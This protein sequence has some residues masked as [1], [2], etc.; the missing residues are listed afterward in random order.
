[1]NKTSLILRIILTFFFAVIFSG[2]MFAQSLEERVKKNPRQALSDIKSL[3]ADNP[4][5]E[6]TL[7]LQAKAYENLGEQDTAIRLYQVFI[8]RYPESPEAYLNLA[9]IYAKKGNTNKARQLLEQGLLSKSEYA[10]LYQSLKKLNSHL[11]QSAY[12]R[13]LSKDKKLSVPALATASTLSLPEIRI[14]EVEVIK[15]I[16]VEV[17]KRVEVIKE[18]PVE[19]IKEVEIVKEVEVIREVVKEIPVAASSLAKNTS[20]SK[21]AAT[22]DASVIKQ[23]VKNKDL[24]PLVEQWA[25]AW[26]DQN[27]GRF[28]SFY[29]P[30]YASRGK[31]RRQWLQDRKL[32]LTNKRFINVKVSEFVQKVKDNKT[33]DITFKQNYQSDVVQGVSTK[34]LTFKNYDGIWKIVAE[35]IIR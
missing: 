7:F 9:N 17:V 28:V 35:R 29:S 16:P 23:T 27:V 24:V 6:S 25:V 32:K 15:E 3:L 19:V 12:Q 20:T 30:S 22:P 1:M 5:N 13:A 21:A 33:V 11:A 18:V 14:R 26:S 34:R 31:N 8:S 4:D 10:K 2:Q